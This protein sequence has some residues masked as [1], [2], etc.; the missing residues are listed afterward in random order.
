ML[1]HRD[2]LSLANSG[3]L[4]FT[5]NIVEL[6]SVLTKN[7]ELN[8]MVD[9]I[10]ALIIDIVMVCVQTG[11]KH[12]LLLSYYDATQLLSINGFMHASNLNI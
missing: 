10:F 1:R 11:A 6:D 12:F 8:G 2:C 4:M 3:F 9:M 7:R 5:A